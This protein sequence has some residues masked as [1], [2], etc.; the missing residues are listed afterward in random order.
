MRK[1]TRRSHH[2][3][4]PVDLMACPQCGQAR[5]SHRACGNCGYVNSHTSIKVGAQES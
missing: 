1:R 4:T 5:Q 3:K 2:A